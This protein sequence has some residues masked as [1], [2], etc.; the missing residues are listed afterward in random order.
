MLT[1]A[2]YFITSMF[3]LIKC[4]IKTSL[5]CRSQSKIALVKI[6]KFFITL[7]FAIFLNNLEA[8]FGHGN[9]IYFKTNTKPYL[10]IMCLLFSFWNHLF[11]NYFLI[12][13]SLSKGNLVIKV[14]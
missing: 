5:T 11:A 14:L 12:P 3:F 8:L 13:K 6:F 9:S 10:K 7:H 2:E 4:I 1:E